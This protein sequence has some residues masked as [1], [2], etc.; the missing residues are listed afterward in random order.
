MFFFFH[1][2]SIEKKKRVD[3]PVFAFILDFS[4]LQLLRSS[5]LLLKSDMIA[6]A[7]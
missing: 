3:E 1:F 7:W 2:H 6:E 4:S 5:L